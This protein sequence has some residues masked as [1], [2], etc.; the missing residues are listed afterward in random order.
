MNEKWKQI[1]DFPKYK[2]SNTGKI[3]SNYSDRLLRP[4][5]D[6]KGYRRVHLSRVGGRRKIRQVHRL[7]AEAFLDNPNCLPFINH[8]DFDP[9][10]NQVNNLEWCTPKWNIRHSVL[11]GRHSS[12]HEDRKLKPKPC[13][14]CGKSFKP[15]ESK[16]RFCSKLCA[17]RNNSVYANNTRRS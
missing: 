17:N 5:V 15:K 6:D 1:K 16:V 13:E 9:G 2:V 12:Q 11:H 10:N 4:Y 3:Y 14:L 8:K 7:V